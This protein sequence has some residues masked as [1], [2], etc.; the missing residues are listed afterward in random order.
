MSSVKRWS[1]P[2]MLTS[3]SLLKGRKDTYLLLG[4]RWEEGKNVTLLAPRSSNPILIENSSWVCLSVKAGENTS[5]TQTHLPRTV[6]LAPAS[7][8]HL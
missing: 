1:L 7:A 5:R 3:L 2:A 8:C 6:C 4:L